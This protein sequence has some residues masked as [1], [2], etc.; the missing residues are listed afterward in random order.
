MIEPTLSTS[1][2]PP[3]EDVT[4]TLYRAAIG[5]VSNGY[6]L[7]IFS[8][9]EAADRAGISW[10]T[11]AGLLTLNWLVFR[12]LWVAALA[13]VGAVV[14]VGLLVFGIGHLVFQ[15]SG[16][17][18]V[19]LGVGFGLAAFVLPGL[20][21][22]ALFHTECRKAMAKALT[23]HANVADARNALLGQASDR[24][25]LIKLAAANIAVLLVL[26][27][28]YQQFS[29]LRNVAV[30]P[31]GALEAGD[32]GLSRATTPPTIPITMAP[33]NIASAVA[34]AAE[35]VASAAASQPASEP[36]SAPAPASTP[37]VP[38]AKAARAVASAPEA[39]PTPPKAST[40]AASA[41]SAKVP[42]KEPAKATTKS[43][44]INVGLFGVPEN[45]AKA[46]AK[47][48]E[49]GLPSVMKELKSKT[50]QIRVRV[51]P[52]ATAAQAEAAAQKIKSLQLDASMVQL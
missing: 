4:T 46:H 5:P 40:K 16:G 11:A 3:E 29:A 50:R 25:R 28:A 14:A 13:Y 20:F 41:P 26:G 49:A 34:S 39:K 7:P 36:V 9:F 19:A 37:V 21:G 12:K 32:V 23:G 18:L 45:A 31:H 10:N 2:P 38:K 43:F 6:Y 48:L 47:L 24:N 44:Y 15:F 42:A 51:G 52:F 27:L 33:A 1:T 8:R 35:P 17:L 22:N 30:M